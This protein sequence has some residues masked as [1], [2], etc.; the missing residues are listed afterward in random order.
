MVRYPLTCSF[1]YQFGSC[2]DLEFLNEIVWKSTALICPPST[3]PAVYQAIYQ[4]VLFGIG[5]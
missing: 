4:E 1:V 2:R 3:H 5:K